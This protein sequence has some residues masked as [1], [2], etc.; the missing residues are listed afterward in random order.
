M[1]RIGVVRVG[2]W[3]PD[4]HDWRFLLD[5]SFEDP[6]R[7]LRAQPTFLP[8]RIANFGL[9]CVRDQG[10][11][12]NRSVGSTR[13]PSIQKHGNGQQKGCDHRYATVRK[14]ARDQQRTGSGDTGDRCKDQHV[15]AYDRPNVFH[16]HESARMRARFAGGRAF[17]FIAARETADKVCVCETLEETWPLAQKRGWRHPK[18]P[19]R[20]RRAQQQ[21]ELIAAIESS[22][23]AEVE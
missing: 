19:W 8:D 23:R 21:T 17:P 20:S 22:R 11:D 2:P 14:S 12:R 10:R 5:P 1:Q 9:F 4:A 6:F 16:R 18:R 3:V 15:R 7:K 13:K